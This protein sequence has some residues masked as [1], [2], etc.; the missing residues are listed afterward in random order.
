MLTSL[1]YCCFFS[2]S[3]LDKSEEPDFDMS[4]P[5][6]RPRVPHEILFVIGGWSGGRPIKMVETYDT[7]ADRWVICKSEDSSKY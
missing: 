1:F 3:E 2:F 7:R 6:V 4:L 5:F